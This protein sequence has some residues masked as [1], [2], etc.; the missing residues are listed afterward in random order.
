MKT[1]AT[2]LLLATVCFFANG[3]FDKGIQ[4]ELT[5]LKAQHKTLQANKALVLRAHEEV[6]NSGNL[7]IV[8]ELYSENYVSHWA[9]G[10]DSDREGLK[11]MVAEA[12]AAFPDMREDIVHTVAEGD[13]VVSHFISSGTFT[14]EMNGLQPSGKTI[15][16]PEIAVH[17]V[18][19]GKI[20][21]QW[22]V[23]DQMTLMKQLGLM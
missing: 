18:A 21:E 1:L 7:I 23:S 22:T 15:T 14:G 3:C 8:D 4:D 6:W 20:V 12:R 19:D 16:R 17:R 2:V 11:N 9:Y 10:D 13:L 5:E